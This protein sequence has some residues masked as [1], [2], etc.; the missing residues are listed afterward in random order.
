MAIGV[1]S[2][3]R[4]LTLRVPEDVSVVGID[5][6]VLARFVGLTT[7]RQPVTQLGQ[8]AASSMLALIQQRRLRQVSD[9]PVVDTVLDAVL[10][11]RSSSAAPVSPDQRASTDRTR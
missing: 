4:E 6:H 1:L 3:A 9:A 10:V 7:V 2:A 8:L 5:D 11:H